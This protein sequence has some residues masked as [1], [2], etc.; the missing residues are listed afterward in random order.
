[1]LEGNIDM[2]KEKFNK[3]IRFKFLSVMSVI[4]FLG[5]LVTSLVIAINEGKV[6]KH[7]LMTTGQSFASYMA[8]LSRDPLIMKDSIQLDAIV[9]DANKDENITYTIIRDGQGAPITTQYAS[10]NYRLPRLNG[11]LLEL[12]RD[13]ELQDIA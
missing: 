11:I 12:S 1:M 3:S 7:S 6:L 10:I 13:H 5:T 9:T 8:K 2:F 4:L